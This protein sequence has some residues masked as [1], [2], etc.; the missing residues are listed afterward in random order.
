MTTIESLRGWMRAALL[1]GAALLA[2]AAGAQTTLPLA[3]NQAKYFEYRIENVVVAPVPAAAVPTW[4]VK[5]IFSVYNPD[6]QAYWEIK[7][8]EPFAKG[9]LT[10]DIGWNPKT[11]FTNTGSANAALAPL[12]TFGS[13]A[14]LPVQVR[15]LTT[16][17]GSTR[18]AGTTDCPNVE[19]AGTRNVYWVA[20]NVTPTPAVAFGRVALEGRPVCAGTQLTGCPAPLTSS[21]GT[22][23]YAN[24]P[25][26][27]ATADFAFNTS[28]PLAAK[29]ANQRRQVVDIAKCKGCHDDRKHG[30][31]V[32]PRLSLHGA[33][34]NENLDLCVA[35]HNPNQTDVPYRYAE[36]AD[37]RLG[38]AETPIDFKVMVHSIHAGGFRTTPYVVV[39]FN[40][41]VN[42][43]SGVRFPAELRKSCPLCH[44]ADSTGRWSFELPLPS[45]V[46]GTTIR[47]QSVYQ[48][49]KTDPARS[50][51]VNPAN[52]TKISP[53]AAT[54]SAC[55]TSSEVR[56]HMVQTGGASFAT[57][58]A[59]IGKSVIE[60]CHTC[61]GRGKD[62][63]VRKVHE[64]FGFSD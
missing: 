9:S 25:A 28:T 54:C 27:S 33:N 61:H 40:S 41:S 10:V 38:A 62:K 7:T 26:R 60:R 13:G 47:T 46:L 37:P 64:L 36:P 18:C 39:G 34:R 53:T 31:V 11:D 5:V 52:D 4:N 29:V 8:A 1:G 24:V 42:D 56:S 21:T 23:T 14:A 58:Q 32:V 44:V 2:T 35:C 48:V 55:H 57:T 6:Q 15:G 30:D 50:I 59:E 3:W 16:A 49:A 20:R 63:D 51:D 19:N 17:A 22:V 12:A 43:F 45:T